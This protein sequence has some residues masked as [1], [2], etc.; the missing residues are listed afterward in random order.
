MVI[1]YL[2]IHNNIFHS[3]ALQN[4]PKLGLWVWKY[5]IWQPWFRFPT[6]QLC[7]IFIYIVFLSLHWLETK[8]RIFWCSVYFLNSST[9]PHR[10][11]TLT[12]LITYTQLH[13]GYIARNVVNNALG[14]LKT[15]WPGGSLF[16]LGSLSWKLEDAAHTFLSTFFHG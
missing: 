11:P 12:Y 15:G 7:Y 10:L 6:R 16:T 2:H 13:Y 4:L 9:E 14:C 1:E 5:T 8:S 3:K